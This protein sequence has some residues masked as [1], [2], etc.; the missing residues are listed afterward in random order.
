MDTSND[1]SAIDD[2]NAALHLDD[3][4]FAPRPEEGWEPIGESIKLVDAGTDAGVTIAA[5]AT[6][7]GQVAIRQVVTRNDAGEPL[8]EPTS[9]TLQLAPALL[10]QLA[11]LVPPEH[12]DP[13]TGG[14][15][16]IQL[17]PGPVMNDVVVEQNGILNAPCAAGGCERRIQIDPETG[18]WDHLPDNWGLKPAHAAIVPSAVLAQLEQEQS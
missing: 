18:E 2:P 9:T 5:T 3:A 10:I 6:N 16:V 11:S 7:M 4:L 12:L 15:D 17:H 8:A 13:H 1:G 14:A